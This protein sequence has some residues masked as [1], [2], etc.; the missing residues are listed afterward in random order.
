MIVKVAPNRRDGKSSFEDLE[1][2]ITEGI[3]QSGDRAER[4]SWDRLTQYITK[5]S[6]LNELGDDVEKTIAV[7][8][9]NVTSLKTAASEMFAVANRNKKVKNPVYH[10][11]LSWPEQ[12]RPDVQDMMAAARH[13]L[14]ALGLLEHQYIIAIHANTDNIHAHVEVNRVS[15]V[16][17]LA[18]DLAWDHSRLHKAAREAE[19]EFGWSHDPGLYEV[20]EVNGHKHV[21]KNEQYVDPELARAKGGANRFETWNGEQ[22]LETWCRGEPAAELKRAIADPDTASWQTLHRT[23]AQFGLELRDSGGGG[24]QVVDVSSD[25]AGKSGRP[26]A[27][28]A[29]KAFRF[30]KR[31]ELEQRFGAFERFDPAAATDLAATAKTYKRDPLKRLDRRLARKELRDALHDRFA[32]EQRALRLRS[33][34]TKAELRQSFAVDEKARYAALTAQHRTQ[35]QAVRNDALLSPKQKQQAYSLLSMTM[36]Q[37]KV[38][39]KEQIRQ[40][41]EARRELLPVI[42]TWREWV[43]QQSQLGDEAAISALRGM[44]YQEKRDAKKAGKD[45]DAD[46]A[47]PGE[48]AIRPAVRQDSDPSVR[49]IQNIIWKVTGTGR[50][51]YSFK[52]GAAGFT[53]QGDKLTFGRKD[54]S[55]EALLVTLHYAKEKWGNEIYLAGGDAVFKARAARLA[56]TLGLTVTNPELQHLTIA[57]PLALPRRAYTIHNPLGAIDHVLLK[58][59]PTEIGEIGSEPPPAA[60]AGL[61][62]LSDL[63]MVHD[64][65]AKQTRPS[66]VLLPDSVSDELEFGGT[67]RNQQVRRPVHGAE[68]LSAADGKGIEDVVQR[69]N[70]AARIQYATTQD[71][72][73]SGQIV[74]HQDGM[75]AQHMGRDSY[76]LHAQSA[77]R[78]G[79]PAVGTTL[80]VRYQSGTANVITRNKG[81]RGGK[82]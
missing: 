29:S 11:I 78:G 14:K 53:D 58:P 6:V 42:P 35:R 22:S 62:K 19:I 20:V 30:L 5:E 40:E 59:Y 15:P 64:G 12:E 1:A 82:T 54:V 65:G 28:S 76:V 63:R 70:P 25:G 51:V 10:Y 68:R 8:I 37:A 27:V 79:V 34:I 50:V 72:A 9:G 33:T 4:T 43:E 31:V 13:T 39:L 17:Y 71:K 80:T 32:T 45:I 57:K 46:E 7:E 24:M 61:R 60:R 18:P 74:A 77:F 44:I 2:Y 48:N 56:G 66:E 26:V 41:R 36:L 16:T 55:D 69:L 21:V 47:L 75:V 73:Y 67:E 81:G 3:E 38:Q 49:A 23:L 52:D